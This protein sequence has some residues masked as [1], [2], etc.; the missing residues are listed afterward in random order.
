MLS[1]QSGNNEDSSFVWSDGSFVSRYVGF[2]AKGQPDYHSGSC[3]KVFKCQ[4][5]FNILMYC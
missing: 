5:I 3:A 2:W 1:K 4:N